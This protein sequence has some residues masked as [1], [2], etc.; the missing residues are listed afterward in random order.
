MPPIDDDVI[1]EDEDLEDEDV[2]TSDDDDDVSKRL[3]KVEND[4]AVLQLLS[5][6]DVARVVQM[7]REG[8][9]VRVDAGD[10][11]GDEDDSEEFDDTPTGQ[12]MKQISNLV[13][14][15]LSPLTEEL[16]GLKGVATEVQKR[17]INKEI[18]AVNDEFGDLE[19]YKE[20]MLHLSREIP[21]LSVREYYLISKARSGK[22]GIMKE[23]TFTEKPTSQPR[24]RVGRNKG[25]AQ[26][27][28]SRR[29]SFN[30]A[31]S[32]ALDGLDLSTLE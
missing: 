25:A 1:L 30:D 7:K 11:E 14:K 24:K 17:E 5:D 26:T 8:K 13:D 19:K 15:K 18:K 10:T 3:E 28:K 27:V 32:N 21:G 12:L 22:L 31:L 29:T 20:K 6:P 4:Q 2:E 23:Q 9:Q 16:D